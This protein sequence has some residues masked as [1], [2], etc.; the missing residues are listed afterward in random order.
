MK[1]WNDLWLNEGFASYMQFKALNVVHP[2]WDIVNL[3]FYNLQ[4]L[5]ISYFK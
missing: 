4:V 2:E 3:L 5:V 1:W